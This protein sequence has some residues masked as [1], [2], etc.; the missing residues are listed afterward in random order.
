MP[1]LPLDACR[2][3]RYRH[4]TEQAHATEENPIPGEAAP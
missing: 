3:Q 2:L 4:D 1:S